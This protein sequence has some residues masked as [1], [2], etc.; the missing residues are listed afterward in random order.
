M[1]IKINKQQLIN[2]NKDQTKQNETKVCKTPL[3]SF[4]VDQL[5]LAMG[6]T[7]NCG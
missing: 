6:S 3:S 1:E 2:Q 4:C 7:L 5:L